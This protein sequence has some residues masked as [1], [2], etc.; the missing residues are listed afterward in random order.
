RRQPVQKEFVSFALFAARL[1]R[2]A[3]CRGEFPGC[4][5][6]GRVERRTRVV[7]DRFSVT[8][9]NQDHEDR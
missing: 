9:E 1:W 2:G 6:T 7:D 5:M 4:R 3:K 8:K